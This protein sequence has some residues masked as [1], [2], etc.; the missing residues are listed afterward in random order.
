PSRARVAATFSETSVGISG[1][2][3]AIIKLIGSSLGAIA[4]TE[5][6]V[7]SV[8]S[9][10]RAPSSWIWRLGTA[11]PLLLTSYPCIANNW[12]DIH[13]QQLNAPR[14]VI[15]ECYPSSNNGLRTKFRRPRTYGCLEQL[16]RHGAV[17]SDHVIQHPTSRTRHGARTPLKRL[18]RTGN[19]LKSSCSAPLGIP[20]V[21]DTRR[22]AGSV[23]TTWRWE[24]CHRS[25][26]IQALPRPV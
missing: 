21:A 10:R 13:D 7:T 14:N 12:F 24:L 1:I 22:W 15:C 18:F 17:P 6:T 23:R 4:G 11:I 8:G 5:G 20:A 3:A 9:Q 25:I 26:P 19:A 2:T 16:V